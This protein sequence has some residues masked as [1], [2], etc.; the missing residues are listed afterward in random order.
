[1]RIP[2]LARWAAIGCLVIPAFCAPEATYSWPAPQNEVRLEGSVKIP[3]RD[4]TMLS[5]DLYFP[6]GASARLP[7]ILIRTPYD[8]APYRKPKST[9][10]EFAAQ[11]YIVAVQDTRGRH[12]SEGNYTAFEGDV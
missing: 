5:T 11:G 1:M 10:Y 7:V 2:C 3:M 4:K 9:A 6:V 12:E 8:K